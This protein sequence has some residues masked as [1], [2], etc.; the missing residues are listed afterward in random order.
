MRALRVIFLYDDDVSVRFP[1]HYRRPMLDYLPSQYGIQTD[2]LCFNSSITE[3]KF[4]KRE[5]GWIAY[6]PKIRPRSLPAIVTEVQRTRKNIKTAI[7]KIIQ[8]SVIHPT[9][10]VAFNY[11]L[12]L[13]AAE[14]WARKF[15]AKFIVH[16]GF[17]MPEE[18]LQRPSFVHKARGFAGRLMRNSIL[19]RADQVWAM[20][21][22]MR[23]LF[24]SEL[25]L[26]EEKVKVWPSGVEVNSAS[27]FCEDRR[28]VYRKTLGLRR[29]SFGFIYIG[30]LSRFRK[31]EILIDAMG[32]LVNRGGYENTRLI[33]IGYAPSVE[34]TAYLLERARSKRL[35]NF[36]RV[37]PSVSEDELPCYIR[38]CDVGLSPIEPNQ[39]LS[40]SSPVKILEY[41][42]VGLPV[43]ASTIP[44]QNLV[45]SESEGGVLVGWSPHEFAR[46]MADMY[47]LSPFQRREMGMRGFNWLVQHREIKKLTKD[48]VSW[49]E[50]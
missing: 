26:R 43:I 16:I 18:L 25:G 50:N 47:K 39:V 14:V 6:L 30:A 45:I 4:E 38:A 11:P 44:D 40:Y 31:L 48:M 10:F 20:S 33:F 34:D 9:H 24:I 7:T 8:G 29:E 32:M 19:R 42:K 17:L 2:V 13:R 27:E 3:V 5:N 46:A 49:L 12:F 23:S 21:D 1:A 22:A 41:F 37:Y 15:S 35:E 36:V 28:E